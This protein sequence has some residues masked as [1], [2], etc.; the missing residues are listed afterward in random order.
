MK[1]L[2][3]FIPAIALTIFYGLAA[4]GGMGAIHPIV[5]LWLALLWIAGIFLSKTM[6]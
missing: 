2:A 5:V 4:F 1:K 3:F 6:F